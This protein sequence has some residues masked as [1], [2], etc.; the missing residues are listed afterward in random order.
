MHLLP[1]APHL[2]LVCPAVTC[3]QITASHKLFGSLQEAVRGS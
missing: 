3:V 1:T 2:A